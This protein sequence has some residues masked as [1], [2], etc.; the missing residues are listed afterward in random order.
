MKKSI[1]ISGICIVLIGLAGFFLWRIFINEHEEIEKNMTASDDVN[2]NLIAS[3]NSE[4]TYTYEI[5][6]EP[7]NLE[8]EEVSADYQPVDNE[9]DV[10]GLSLKL[11][12]VNADGATL[13]FTQSGGEINGQLYTGDF[14][15]LEKLNDGVWETVDTVDSEYPLVWPDIAYTINLEGETEFPLNWNWIY[16]ELSYGH[17]RIHKTVMDHADMGSSDF[18]DLWVEFDI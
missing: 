12:K 4:V 16:G 15:E 7:S 11:Q 2:D 1:I 17:Y 8:P 18:Y 5:N 14:F 10:I 3:Y 9:T 6:E 13:V